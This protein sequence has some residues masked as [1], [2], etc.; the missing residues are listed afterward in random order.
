MEVISQ[1]NAIF[2]TKGHFRSP[3]RSC[4]IGLLCCKMVLVCQ[5]SVSQLRNTLRNGALAAKIGDFT[6]WGFRNHFAAAKWGYCAAKWHSCAKGV[7]RSCENFRRGGVWGCEIISQ[8]QGTYCEIR[9]SLRNE[10]FAAKPFRSPIATPYENF[11]S[12]ETLLWHT[13]AIS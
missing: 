8:P 6:L 4:E 2:A 10:P 13:S 9:G 3:F 12:Y 7:F 5:R 1:P 11:C